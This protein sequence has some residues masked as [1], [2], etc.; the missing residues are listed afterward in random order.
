MW[1][2]HP[3]VKKALGHTED[4]DDGLFWMDKHEALQHF[5]SFCVCMKPEKNGRRP[6]QDLTPDQRQVRRLLST[7]QGQGHLI[8]GR[9]Q[10]RFQGGSLHGEGTLARL[11]PGAATQPGANGQ[12]V[13]DEWLAAGHELYRGEFRLGKMHGRGHHMFA[14]GSS[15]K[16]EYRDHMRHGQG[17][18]HGGGGSKYEGEWDR[19]KKHGKGKFVGADGSE[20]DGEYHMDRKH[21]HG[22]LTLKSGRYDGEFVHDQKHGAGELQAPDARHGE[23]LS[24]KRSQ[25]K[26]GHKYSRFRSFL[27]EELQAA[28]ARGEQKRVAELQQDLDDVP[29]AR[30]SYKGEWVRGKKHGHGTHCWADGS[31]YEGEWRMDMMH[32][33]GTY[34]DCKGWSFGPREADEGRHSRTNSPSSHRSECPTVLYPTRKKQGDNKAQRPPFEG[35]RPT[36]GVL[37]EAD[38]RKFAVMYAEDCCLIQMGPKPETKVQI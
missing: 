7:A 19:N 5:W 4:P 31:K 35:G 23:Y 37:H 1:K 3:D 27:E 20:Y 24:G 34:S 25:T 15:Y 33:V 30:W 18:F 28:Q 29:P 6:P 16:G 11:H 26:S 12:W 2:E 21:G 14:D 32:G 36:E 13:G 38:G 10:G 22:V 9:Y 8:N 17:I